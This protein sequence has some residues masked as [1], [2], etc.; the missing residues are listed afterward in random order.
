[1][2]LGIISDTHG[3]LRPEALAALR[4]VDHIVHAGDVGHGDIVTALADLAPLT[5]V[6]GNVDPRGAWPE[7]AELTFDALR[8]VVRHRIEDIESADRQDVVIVGH[9]HKPRVEQKG[10]TLEVNPGSAGPRRFSL[11][12]TLATL[13][14]VEGAPRVE[15]IRLL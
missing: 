9:S 12:I 8:I 3:L 10:A 11:P 1:M 2:I 14:V 15:I 7:R 5:V 13:V 4:G 6:G